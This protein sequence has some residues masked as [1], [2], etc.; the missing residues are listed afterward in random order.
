MCQMMCTH[1][2][3]LTVFK[4]NEINELYNIFMY[5]YTYI[6]KLMSTSTLYRI[7]ID[8]TNN[9]IELNFWRECDGVVIRLPTNFTISI[10]SHM[11]SNNINK[12]KEDV[13]KHVKN[14]TQNA[15]RNYPLSIWD[16]HITNLLNRVFNSKLEYGEYEEKEPTSE[17][18]AFIDPGGPTN[19]DGS[20][21]IIIG[22]AVEI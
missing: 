2:I 6:H 20:T 13:L 7:N 19:A 10:A 9:Y 5:I 12:L 3:T 16:K 1:N 4:K 21:T 11:Y 8:G 18:M 14:P 22:E 15:I 17:Y